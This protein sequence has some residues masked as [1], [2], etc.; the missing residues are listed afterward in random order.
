ML[1]N[2]GQALAHPTS[3]AIIVVINLLR[4]GLRSATLARS[5]SL[6]DS[7]SPRAFHAGSAC[8]QPWCDSAYK[9]TS[10]AIGLSKL[11]HPTRSAL[12]M[13]ALLTVSPSLFPERVSRAHVSATSS[14]TPVAQES[15]W[16]VSP[17]MIL[18]LT[19]RRFTHTLAPRWRPGPYTA[20]RPRR[21]VSSLPSS[22]SNFQLEL[23][24]LKLTTLR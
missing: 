11:S 9:D 7:A 2:P 17:A 12:V 13:L 15:R 21:C 22:P 18:R 1:S 19:T 10:R 3:C 20:W 5:L 6:S 24:L 4:S 23:P 8:E 14:C 16:S